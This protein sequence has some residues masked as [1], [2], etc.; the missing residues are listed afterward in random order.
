MMRLLLSSA[1]FGKLF[2]DDCAAS[3][4]EVDLI[5]AGVETEAADART[6]EGGE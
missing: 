1:Y 4:A 6:G 5:P 2:A 3:S